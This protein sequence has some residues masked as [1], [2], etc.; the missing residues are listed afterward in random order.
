VRDLEEI[1]PALRRRTASARWASITVRTIF[2]Y[3]R[4]ELC[5]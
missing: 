1:S 5:S 2:W 4:D 3:V